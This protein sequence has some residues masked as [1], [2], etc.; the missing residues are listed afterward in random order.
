MSDRIKEL[1]RE[2]MICRINYEARLAVGF[3]PQLDTRR[4]IC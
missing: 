4:S 2:H 1:A 3:D